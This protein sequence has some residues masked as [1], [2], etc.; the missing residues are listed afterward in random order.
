MSDVDAISMWLNAVKNGDP[1][2]AQ[3]LWDRYFPSLVRLAQKKLSWVP[4]KLEDEEDVALSALD[5][6]C[7]AADKGRFPHV[8]DRH[9]LW[10]LLC[11]ITHR[12]AVDLIRRSQT[13]MGDARVLGESCFAGGTSSTRQPMAAQARPAEAADLAVLLAEEVQRLLQMLPDDELKTIAIA[14]MDGHMNREIADELGCAERTI[15][16][17]L[18]YIRA[19]WKREIQLGREGSSKRS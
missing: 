16:R 19:I 17:R 8:N 4:R 6:F 1:N 13:G 11:R 2:A 3:K 7:R 10:K 14:R 15:E 9:S 12:K 5:S 18:K